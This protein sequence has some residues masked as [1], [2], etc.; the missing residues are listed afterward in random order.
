MPQR[1]ERFFWVYGENLGTGAMNAVQAE[2]NRFVQEWNNHNPSYPLHCR[3]CVVAGSPD[4]QVWLFRLQLGPGNSSIATA[5]NSELQ[6]HLKQV[7]QAH[8]IADEDLKRRTTLPTPLMEEP[9]GQFPTTDIGL[10][11]VN[12]EY[13]AMLVTYTYFKG[14]YG[15]YQPPHLQASEVVNVYNGIMP[16]WQRIA[17]GCHHGSGC[18]NCGGIGCYQCFQPNCPM[19]GGTGWKEFEQ[20][21]ANGY[22]IDYTSGYPIA[23]P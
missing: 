16:K 12:D 17:C 22:R 4:Q 14:A 11:A 1:L 9:F 15:R 2:H 21:A 7:R 20:W 23:V 5:F 3:P 19:C 13:N 6:K 18:P 10:H 8:G